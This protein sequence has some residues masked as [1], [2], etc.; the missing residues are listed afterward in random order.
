[1]LNKIHQWASPRNLLIIW[2]LYFI[3]AGGVMPYMAKKMAEVAGPLNPLDLFVPTY[4][5]ETAHEMV[6]AYGEAGRAIYR[7]IELTAD[8]IY[9]LVYGLAFALLIAFLWKKAAPHQSWARYL[10]LL[11]FVTVICDLLENSMIVIL[12]SSYPEQSDTVAKM[13]S[14]FS[15][16]K[17]TMVFVCATA[18]IGGLLG[19]LIKG[20]LK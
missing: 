13:A 9:P 4:S 15:L 7:N 1:M 12:L 2:I 18:I 8:V 14:I 19:W 5:V 11:A 6:A 3:M 20:R 17:W 10:P 16:M